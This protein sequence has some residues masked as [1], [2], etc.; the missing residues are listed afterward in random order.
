M[1]GAKNT[2]V[3]DE[4]V[5]GHSAEVFFEVDYACRVGHIDDLR[6]DT[7]MGVFV[8]CVTH[9]RYHVGALLRESIRQTA[10]NPARCADNQDMLYSHDFLTCNNNEPI[11]MG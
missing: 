3:D 1:I 8:R 5:K 6:G 11:L 7:R 4:R 10:A 2:G 9:R